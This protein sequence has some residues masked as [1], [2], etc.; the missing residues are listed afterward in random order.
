MWIDKL[1]AARGPD[2]WVLVRP[3]VI[4]SIDMTSLLEMAASG[5]RERLVDY[6]APVSR[7]LAF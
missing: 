6:T 4:N 5:D 3:I 7:R 2:P 1:R